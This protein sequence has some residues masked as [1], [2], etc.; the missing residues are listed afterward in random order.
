MPTYYTRIVCHTGCMIRVL[1]LRLRTINNGLTVLVSLL[2]LYVIAMPLLPAISWWAKYEA[3]VISKPVSVATPR[4]APANNTL[5]IPSLALSDIIHEGP[6]YRTLRIGPW[7]I[8]GTGSPAKGGNTVIAGHR[9]TYSGSGV[10]Y[11]LD[12]VRVGDPIYVYWQHKRYAYTVKSTR[13]VAPTDVAIEAP[14]K[15]PQ[16]TLYT[17]TPMWT[18][19]NRLV[20]VAVPTGDN[21]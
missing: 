11:H 8:P 20:I 16:L 2:A 15:Q 4:T 21:P 14:T 17:C 9:Y 6:D 13:V 7:H 5:V 1:P 10:F 19:S 18:F 12:K 3:P